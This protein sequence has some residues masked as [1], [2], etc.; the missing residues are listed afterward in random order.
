MGGC[1]ARLFAQ[2]FDAVL[3]VIVISAGDTILA[4]LHEKCLTRLK[5][6]ILTYRTYRFFQDTRFFEV[7]LRQ[8]RARARGPTWAH[9]DI[10]T[11]GYSHPYGHTHARA[12]ATP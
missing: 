3:V 1:T 9:M 11:V 7:W 4:K 8:R 2:N 12:M 6:N 5:L 10:P